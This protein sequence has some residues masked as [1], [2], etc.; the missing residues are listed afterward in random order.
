MATIAFFQEDS[1][2]QL[3]S[4][5]K[6]KDWLIRLAK[7]EGYTISELNYI[8]CS[9]EYL[10]NINKE[11]LD[12]NYYTDIITFDNSEGNHQI[13]GDIFISIDRVK[14]NAVENQVSTTEELHRVLAHGLLHLMGYKDKTILETQTMRSKEDWALSIRKF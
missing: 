12:H 3:K 8:F 9:D 2:Y 5:L 14:E 11:Y 4:K 6:I 13:E 10:L 7:K 1:T